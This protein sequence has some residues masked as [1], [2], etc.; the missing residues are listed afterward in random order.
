MGFSPAT[1]RDRIA[2]AGGTAP[3]GSRCVGERLTLMA[4]LAAA[5]HEAEQRAARRRNHVD[6]P[7]RREEQSAP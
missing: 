3:L 2:A 5:L 7:E 4:A 1:E 6:V